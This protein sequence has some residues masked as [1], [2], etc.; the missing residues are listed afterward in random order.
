M[1]LQSWCRSETTEARDLA[2]LSASRWEDVLMFAS[3][4]TQVNAREAIETRTSSRVNVGETR[5]AGLS[6][7]GTER[8]KS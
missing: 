1:D 4:I 6:S 3:T 7:A 2:G 8:M 5:T